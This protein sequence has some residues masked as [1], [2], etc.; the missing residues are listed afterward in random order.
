[1]SSEV[2]VPALPESVADATVLAWHKAPGESVKTG[3]NLVDLETDKVVL[4]VPAMTDGVL[5]PI[6]TPVGAVVTARTVLATIVAAAPALGVG[7]GPRSI[8]ASE[9]AVAAA[10]PPV[11]P[12]PAAGQGA[13]PGPG[14]HHR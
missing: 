1:M 7:S 5:G 11:A 4:E 6:Q 8:T 2:R 14:T 10:D 13:E 9:T 3:E 12:A